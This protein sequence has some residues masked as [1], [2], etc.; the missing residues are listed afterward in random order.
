MLTHNHVLP[1]YV[2]GA[3]FICPD[4]STAKRVT[5]HKNIQTKS[6]TLDGD[7]MDPSG[8]LSGGSRPNTAPLLAQLHELKGAREECTMLRAQLKEIEQQLATMQ[9][10]A[11]AYHNLKS[12]WDIKHHDHELAKGRIEQSSC[13]QV[14]SSSR[15]PPVQAHPPTLHKGLAPISNPSNAPCT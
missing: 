4:M 14:S 9:K 13:S 3:N 8:T 5:F 12:Q 2:F 11:Q 6:V 7:V 10:S 1:R 15:R